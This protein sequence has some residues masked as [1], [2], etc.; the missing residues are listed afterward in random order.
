[1]RENEREKWHQCIN[2]ETLCELWHHLVSEFSY[3]TN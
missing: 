3:D 1:M 2:S